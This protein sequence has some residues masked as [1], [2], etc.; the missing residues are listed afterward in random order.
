MN[1]ENLKDIL[2]Q[3]APAE[4][5]A[6]SKLQPVE[7]IRR[8]YNFGQ[9]NFAENYVQEALVKQQDLE[10][11]SDIQWHLIGHLQKNK[12]KMVV[13]KF[14]LIHSVDSLDLAE[15]LSR[16]CDAK[17]VK[18]NILLQVNLAAAESKEGFSKTDLLQ[19]WN[20]LQ[21]LPHLQILGLM[22]M[23]PLTED[24]QSVRPY[25]KGLRDLKTELEQSRLDDRHTLQHLSMGTSHDFPVAVAEGATL[26][27]LGTILF[28][29]RP[30]K[31]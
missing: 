6:V 16:Q 3:C 30:R 17:N 29:D 27:R 8:L 13:G 4:L 26:V 11:L 14:H 19:S 24:P 18:Q 2:Q 5:L 20:Q 28:G 9:R 12:A 10:D 23:P 25:F 15:V 1:L 31:G 21:K 7:K 22:T